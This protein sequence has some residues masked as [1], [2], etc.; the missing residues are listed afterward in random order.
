MYICGIIIGGYMCVGC[1]WDGP[2]LEL[3]PCCPKKPGYI[4]G[5]TCDIPLRPFD[6]NLLKSPKGAFCFA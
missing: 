3:D 6:L 4:I 1:E 5:G 2:P